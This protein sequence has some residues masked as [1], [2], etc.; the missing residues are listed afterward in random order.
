MQ[1]IIPGAPDSRLP[2]D[3]PA[4]FYHVSVAPHPIALA[5][6]RVLKDAEGHNWD[7]HIEGHLTVAEPRRFLTAYA[8]G[9]ARPETP[10]SRPMVKS[11]VTNQVG[12]QLRDEVQVYVDAQGWEALKDRDGLPASWWAKE[13]SAWLDE[14]GI[15]VRVDAV[16]WQSAAAEQAEAEAAR[17]RDF[18]RMAQARQSEREAELREAA[19]KADYQKRV[20]QIESDWSLSE[21]EKQHQFQLLEKRHRKELLDAD[22]EIENARRAAEQAVLEHEAALA[23]LR[24]DA[25]S[26]QQAEERENEAD[27]RHQQVLRELSRDASGPRPSAGRYSLATGRPK[28]EDGQ[29]GGRAPGVARVQYPGQPAGQAGL[30]RP[31]ADPWWNPFARRPAWMASRCGFARRPWLRVISAP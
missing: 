1:R 15:A 23:R 11:W 4:M 3:R 2:A 20:A 7:C 25:A 8:L 17:R 12:P 19:A 13:F 14:F 16:S 10:L 6:S 22:L 24:Q 30:S 28:R 5:F 18:E 21:Q 26:A 9:V 31:T 29:Y 27:S